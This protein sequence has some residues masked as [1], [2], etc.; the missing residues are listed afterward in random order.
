MLEKLSGR[1]GFTWKIVERFEAVGIGGRHVD[2]D[3]QD[4]GDHQL[5]WVQE[6]NTR[7]RG[8]LP[9]RIGLV[10][11]S[12]IASPR[13]LGSRRQRQCRVLLAEH[14]GAALL[15]HVNIGPLRNGVLKL[16]VTDPAVLYH[17]RLCWEQRLLGLFRDH[18][19]AA[20][21]HTV[22]FTALLPKR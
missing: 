2:K 19:P 9:D 11:R 13:L 7:R 12:L 15:D 14:A 5:R 3:V 10:M 1:L 22:R 16:E 6:N 4:A 20:G 18:L 21:V 17:L 8:R